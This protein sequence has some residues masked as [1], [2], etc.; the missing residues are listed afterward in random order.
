M[1]DE[2]KNYLLNSLI[3]GCLSFTEVEK[4]NADI[5]S[6]ENLKESLHKQVGCTW[7]DVVKNA[8]EQ[9]DLKVLKK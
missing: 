2:Q 7:K 6:L 8:P 1:Q 4:E 9:A 3:S 5:T